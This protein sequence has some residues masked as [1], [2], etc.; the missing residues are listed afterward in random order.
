MS[1]RHNHWLLCAC[2]VIAAAAVLRTAPLPQATTPEEQTKYLIVM[3]RGKIG[4]AETSGAGIIVGQGPDRLYVATANHVVRAGTASATGLEIMLRWTPGEWHRAT[5]TSDFD[6]GL[7]L[8]VILVPNATAL[9]R[10]VKLP[11]ARLAAEVKK[12]QQVF[13]IGYGGG[14]PWS[15]RVT[16]DLV[17]DVTSD[18]V[19]FETSLE[20][21]PGLSGGALV[22]SSAEIVGLVKHYATPVAVAV[23]ITRA[24]EWLK[25]YS[26]PVFLRTA[27]ATETPAGGSA[28][29]GRGGES[30]GTTT[31]PPTGRGDPGPT[32]DP[33]RTGAS[34]WPMAGGD[35]SRSSWNVNEKSLRPPL[36]LVNRFGA[37]GLT[38]E[39][40][41]AA[42]G[43]VYASGLNQNEGRNQVVAFD[44][45]GA[46]AWTFA[47][48]SGKGFGAVPAVVDGKIVIAARADSNVYG[49]DAAT[50]RLVWKSTGGTVAFVRD[51]LV[52]EQAAYV[53]SP[54]ALVAID[55]RDGS[56]MWRM[57][58]GTAVGPPV[59]YGSL[60]VVPERLDGGFT[61][62]TITLQGS[63]R[64]S[65]SIPFAPIAPLVTS[66]VAQV[67]QRSLTTAFV[68]SGAEI[69]ALRLGSEGAI[70][71]NK[72]PGGGRGG[73]PRV[74]VGYG[75]VIAR[76]GQTS[77]E[78][79][80]SVAGESGLFAFDAA[81]GRNAW[82]F[83][84]GGTGAYGPAIAN[85]VA[86]VASVQ[87]PKIFGVSVR[88][89]SE[90]WYSFLPSPPTA[91]PIVANGQLYVA[92]G[93]SIFVFAPERAGR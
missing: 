47:L 21:I 36:A 74:G 45:S 68:S 73:R 54:D 77:Q 91:D 35:E 88:D 24:I 80:G 42:N 3:V 13:P 16:A 85:W 44:A 59:F 55:T 5:L 86:Y 49:V 72:L 6:Q 19:K 93:S 65:L 50:G 20:L 84:T 41:V 87:P 11:V 25:Q 51:V 10:Q 76:L 40:L 70:W 92:M 89:S 22:N 66:L 79:G 39:S 32:T 62:S 28:A 57:K 29:G 90:F 18:S 78:Y 69:A 17:S 60:I 27:S 64:G 43:R 14:T 82:R 38:I 71:R 46:R 4:D 23:P 7:D 83:G 26:Y 52:R 15:T 63:V 58:P 9:L 8:A 30:G 53:L 81:T 1:A 67:G 75:L 37:P 56:T 48:D 2:G 33:I 61:A 31:K 12:T 34:S